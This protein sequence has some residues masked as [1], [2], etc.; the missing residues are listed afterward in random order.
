MLI[1]FRFRDGQPGSGR[2]VAGR[3]RANLAASG[4]ARATSA[5]FYVDGRFAGRDT[6]RPFVRTISR[7]ALRPEAASA[8]RTIRARVTLGDDRAVTVERRVRVCG[9]A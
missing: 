7:A 9:T 8:L 1:G 2:C 3:L 4:A 6:R 5:L